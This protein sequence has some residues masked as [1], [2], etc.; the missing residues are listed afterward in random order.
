MKRL[1]PAWLLAS[2]ALS[3]SFTL[4]I[5]CGGSGPTTTSPVVSP[6]IISPMDP[7]HQSTVAIVPPIPVGDQSKVLLAGDVRF[8]VSVADNIDINQLPN[9]VEVNGVMF[10]KRLTLGRQV[11]QVVIYVAINPQQPFPDNE[12]EEFT[13]IGINVSFSLTVE[14]TPEGSEEPEIL[15][16]SQQSIVE[17]I[18][19][20]TPT[21]TSVSTTGTFTTSSPT[22]TFSNRG[23]TYYADDYSLSTLM[24]GL[25]AGQRVRINHNMPAVDAYLYVL[26]ADTG[27]VIAANDDFGSSNSQVTLTIADGVNYMVVPTMYPNTT[28]ATPLLPADYTLILTLVN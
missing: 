16:V 7:F 5:A 25:V 8:V 17:P 2:I 21:P 14:T 1:F 13:I 22:R 9:E 20:P 6:Q 26:N 4:L 24:P 3:T 11:N 18:R 27:V 19:S 23:G 28:A 12:L 15:F 10:R